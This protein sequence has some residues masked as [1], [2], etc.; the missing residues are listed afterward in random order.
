MQ[1]IK[2]STF[3]VIKWTPSSSAQN[4]PNH[5]WMLVC[6][7]AFDVP[8]NQKV[9]WAGDDTHTPITLLPQTLIPVSHCKKFSCLKTGETERLGCVEFLR[10]FY[11]GATLQCISSEFQ[12]LTVTCPVVICRSMSGSHWSRSPPVH[13]DRNCSPTEPVPSS[14]SPRLRRSSSFSAV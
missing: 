2:S 3:L 10:K 14:S 8:P 9:G 7:G 12:F 6:W 5:G 1:N 4:V 13:R 11:T